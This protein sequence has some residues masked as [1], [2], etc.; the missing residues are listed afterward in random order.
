MKWNSANFWKGLLLASVT[1]T[2][3]VFAVGIRGPLL[4]ALCAALGI[5]NAIYFPMFTEEE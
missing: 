3:A 5:F 2:L 4:I 1:L